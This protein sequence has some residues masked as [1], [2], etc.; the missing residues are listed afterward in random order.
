MAISLPKPLQTLLLLLGLLSTTQIQAAS[1]TVTVTPNNPIS[2]LTGAVVYLVNTS[3]DHTSQSTPDTSGTKKVI[4]Q[5]GKL[6]DPFINVIQTGTEVTFPNRDPVAH[7]VYS[8]SSAQAFELPLY[9]GELA[10][11]ITFKQPGLVT[12]G[13]NIHDWMLGY[14]LVLDTPHYQQLQGLKA[15]FKDLPPGEY[16]LSFWAPDMD[17]REVG[18]LLVKHNDSDQAVLLKL[19]YPLK[20]I[21]QPQPP[22]NSI[23]QLDDYL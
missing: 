4:A 13:C 12:L 20:G 10:P 16:L 23:D 1:L 11:S 8:F 19:T 14:V 15:T 18:Q 3:A 17:Q 6:F 7:H 2:D 21:Q 22:A 5:S 9:K